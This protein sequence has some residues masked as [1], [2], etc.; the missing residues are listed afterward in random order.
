MILN[1]ILLNILIIFYN[2]WF[3]ALLKK[4]FFDTIDCKYKNHC[5]DIFHYNRF[6]KLIDIELSQYNIG[7]RD[8]DTVL[9]FKF[10]KHLKNIVK[11]HILFHAQQ[12]KLNK[13]F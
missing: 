6:L 5:K 3:C 7:N 4:C 12:N 8:N 2:N 9:Y 11:Q 13:S 1:N 10:I